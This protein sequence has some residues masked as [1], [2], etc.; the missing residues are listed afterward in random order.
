MFLMQTSSKEAPLTTSSR[1]LKI[2]DDLNAFDIIVQKTASTTNEESAEFDFFKDMKPI[3]E[4]ISS[5]TM[6]TGISTTNSIANTTKL[7]N[8]ENEVIVIDSGRF[9]A[10]AINGDDT[11]A[12]GDGWGMD[13]DV[14]DVW[15]E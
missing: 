2:N 4:S 12:G 10:V 15:K 11:S 5:K 13:D 14:E 9:A 6:E 8:N 7:P 1:K 3:I